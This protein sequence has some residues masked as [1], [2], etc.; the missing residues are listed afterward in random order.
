MSPVTEVAT[1]SLKAGTDVE[2]PSSPAYA[3]AQEAFSM[4]SSQP[5]FQRAFWGRELEDESILQLFIGPLVPPF[6]HC[7]IFSLLN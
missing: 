2:N 3:V 4:I 5:G 6:F 7:T 1:L